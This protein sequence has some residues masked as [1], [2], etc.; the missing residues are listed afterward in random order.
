MGGEGAIESVVSEFR[1]GSNNGR[2][3][4]RVLKEIEGDKEDSCC[5]AEDWDVEAIIGR[6]SER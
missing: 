3:G 5:D 1:R 2:E 6:E 4:E